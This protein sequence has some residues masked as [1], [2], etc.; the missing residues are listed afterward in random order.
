MSIFTVGFDSYLG[1]AKAKA[2]AKPVVKKALKKPVPPKESK[3]ASVNVVAAHFKRL[4]IPTGK[5]D[6]KLAF[7]RQPAAVIADQVAK[8]VNSLPMPTPPR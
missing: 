4:G 1:A 8:A 2:P 3:Q 6:P 5:P 7:W